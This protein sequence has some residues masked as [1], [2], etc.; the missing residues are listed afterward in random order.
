M[1]FTMVPFEIKIAKSSIGY[2]KHVTYIQ[3]I[4][5]PLKEP[6]I[7]VYTNCIKIIVTHQFWKYDDWIDHDYMQH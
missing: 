3:L 7:A 5:L 1:C 4:T 6:L 2:L